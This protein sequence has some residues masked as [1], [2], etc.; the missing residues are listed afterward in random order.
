M[1]RRKIEIQP[2][3]DD[4]NRTVTFVKRKAGLF[5][6]AYELSV[7]C[8]VDLAV[9]IV[10][11]NNKVYEFLSVD[12]KQL[13]DCYLRVKP[14]ELKLPEH[15]GNY[16]K[17]HAL[18]S[19]D[20]PDLTDVHDVPIDDANGDLDYDSE[21]EPKRHRKLSIYSH[22]PAVCSRFAKLAGRQ[23]IE[24]LPLQRPVLRVQIP[25]DVKTQDDA[26]KTVTADTVKKE[27][28]EPPL[29]VLNTRYQLGKFKSP[30]QKKVPQLPVP[31]GKHLA[32]LSPLLATVPQLPNAMPF[33]ALPQRLPL[34]QYPPALLPTP[35]M[36][37]VF[38]QQYIPQ[39]RPQLL[40]HQ[41]QQQQQVQLQAQQ[42]HQQGQQQ[43]QPDQGPPAQVQGQQQGTEPQNG[44]NMPQGA[45][46]NLAAGGQ[47]LAEQVD[48]PPRFRPPFQQYN[49]D[50]TP[51]LGLPSRYINDI[52]LQ[53]PS[54]LYPGQEW[55]TSMTPFSLNM[56]HYFGQNANGA[57][58]LQGSLQGPL[59]ANAARN[60]LLGGRQPLIQQ[61]Q[62]Q[63]QNLANNTLNSQNPEDIYALQDRLERSLHPSQK[64][65]APMSKHPYTSP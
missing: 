39:H 41:H 1:G 49:G 43:Q 8:Q 55:P 48:D 60:S 20:L 32:T 19:S 14:H 10:G 58:P 51:L 63:Q 26:E 23:H 3:T 33:Y 29:P 40:P 11:N 65:H 7:L 2:L 18:N 31:I 13:L 6:K 61:Q 22:Q 9:I 53:S 28:E 30:E 64:T 38:A 46:Q 25:N 12:T 15:F 17:K 4:R 59:Y 21:P 56:P 57:T 35:V 36:N 27:K 62:Q 54:N 47:V 24:D 16:K 37:Q 34:G 44:G 5:K 45:N 52:F 50:Q 42:L